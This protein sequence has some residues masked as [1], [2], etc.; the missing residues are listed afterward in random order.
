MNFYL[1]LITN[2]IPWK[3]EVE[4]PSEGTLHQVAAMAAAAMELHHPDYFFYHRQSKVL[5]DPDLPLSKLSLLENE[6]IVLI[7]KATGCQTSS[8]SLSRKEP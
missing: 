1:Q 4:N 8:H 5:L 6:G 7:P 3:I 2:P